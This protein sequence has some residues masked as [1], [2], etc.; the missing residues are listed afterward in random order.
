M[1]SDYTVKQF[2]ELLGVTPMTIYRMINAKEL[3]A[4]KVRTATRIPSTEYERLSHENSCG[5]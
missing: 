3:K 2:S 1:K 5:A 4:Y